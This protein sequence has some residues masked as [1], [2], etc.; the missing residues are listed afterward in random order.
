MP[1]AAKQF[2]PTK[3]TQVA[4][5]FRLAPT[6]LIKLMLCIGSVIGLSDH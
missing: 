1:G 2:L 6:A 5:V 4:C 3:V